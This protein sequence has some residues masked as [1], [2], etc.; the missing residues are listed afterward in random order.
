VHV[1]NGLLRV[2]LQRFSRWFESD[3]EWH[4]SHAD[5]VPGRS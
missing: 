5:D 1:R 2:T 3:R 4:E